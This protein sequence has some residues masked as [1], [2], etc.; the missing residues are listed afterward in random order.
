M[1]VI[2]AND[3]LP[4]KTSTF[5]R[6]RHQADADEL[7]SAARQLESREHPIIES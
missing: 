4:V 2:I 7:E 6:Y 5:R 1:A 3:R